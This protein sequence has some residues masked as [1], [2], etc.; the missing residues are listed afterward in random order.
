M[1]SIN[2]FCGL[3]ILLPDT[4]SHV[5]IEDALQQKKGRERVRQNPGTGE[6]NTGEKWEEHQEDCHREPQE[7][8]PA[9]S[10]KGSAEW[11]KWVEGPGGMSP[12]R[13]D[14]EELSNVFK[15]IQGFSVYLGVN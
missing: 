11:I 5:A 4:H 14:I 2:T 10:R 8:C 1:S 13:N 9:S 7:D 3:D 12:R 6:S 15:W